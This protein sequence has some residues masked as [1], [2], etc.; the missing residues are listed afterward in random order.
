MPVVERIPQA[1]SRRMRHRDGIGAPD[2]TVDG[3]LFLRAD[4]SLSHDCTPIRLRA[5]PPEAYDA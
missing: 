5:P 1:R 3:S 4:G 2:N